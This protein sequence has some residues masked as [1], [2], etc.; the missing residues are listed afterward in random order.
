M[1]TRRTTRLVAAFAALSL[2]LTA[3]GTRLDRDTI[4]RAAGGAGGTQ[5]GIEPGLRTDADGG[6]G[7]FDDELPGEAEER[8]KDEVGA[9]GTARAGAAGTPQS[10]GGAHGGESAEKRGDG[11]AGGDPIVIGSVG[12]YSGPAGGALGQ[13][14]RALQ[15]WAADTNARGGINGR[16]IKVIVMDDGGDA[17]RARSQVQEL[18]EEHKAVAMVANLGLTASRKA[19]QPYIEE[20]RFPAIGGSSIGWNDSPMLFNEKASL[21]SWIYGT[22]LI[23]AKFG[24][25]KKFGALFCSEEA[26]CSQLE[27]RWFD[28]GYAKRA[29]LEPVYRAKIS[30]TQPD[31]TAECIQARNSGVEIF[32]VQADP[33][34]LER[35]VASCRRQNFN[36]QYLQVGPAVSADTITKSGIDDVLVS[37][38]TFPFAGL[39]T[40][41]VNEFHAAWRKYGGDKAAGPAA[42]QGW[43]AAKIFEKA[44][45]G[46]GDDISSKSLLK[47]LYSFRKERFAGLTVP[48]TFTTK[49]TS[50]TQCVFYMKGERDKW[51]APQGDKPVCW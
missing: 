39:S 10:G 50:D 20:K 44:A 34:T 47:Q 49:G 2:V 1:T 43:A 13:A 15:A 5:A 46:A 51:V 36:P 42:S 30:I 19:W 45:K 14:P 16:P 23:G 9:D 28:R 29:G 18:V 4:A 35:V 17:A 33:R 8:A 38:F 24:K 21:D 25:G 6:L 32:N 22:V 3:C 37:Q 41:A 7:S 48:L 40:P 12:T 26:S 31:F 27:E 11:A